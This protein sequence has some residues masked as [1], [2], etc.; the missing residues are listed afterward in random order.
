MI[1]PTERKLLFI[2]GLPRAGSTLLS[3]ILAQNPEIHATPTSACHDL[4][5]TIRNNWGTWD[6]HKAS[7]SL[8]DEKN[9]QRVLKATLYNY[10]DTDR[11][12]IF[13]KGRGW[14]HL[15][16]ML[17]FALGYKPKI[18][19][20][21]RSIH[22]IVASFEKLHRKSI[23]MRPERGSF[24]KAQTIRGRADELLAGDGIVGL[25]YNRLQD[26]LSRGHGPNIGLVEFDD[27]TNR[28]NEV[29]DHIYDFL[30]LPR[31]EHNFNNVVQYTQEDDVIHGFK[32]LHV[33]RSKVSPVEDDSVSVLGQEF[34]N[35]LSG[36]EFWRQ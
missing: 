24:F 26:A 5:F 36:K 28:P 18:L 8:S 32:D 19:C 1:T 16:E 12:I 10:H 29:L 30:E 35:S 6:E 4:L 2:S 14:L 31:F 13:D 21:V 20:N 15:Y 27:L 9:L 3:N 17:E 34:V 33:I 11:P 25:A 7:K 22:Q 23:H